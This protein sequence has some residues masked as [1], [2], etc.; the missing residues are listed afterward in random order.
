MKISAQSAQNCGLR[1]TFFMHYGLAHE[2]ADI[3]QMRANPM[4]PIA[5][6]KGHT[7]TVANRRTASCAT[8]FAGSMSIFH[9]RGEQIAF[10]AGGRA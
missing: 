8:S 7:V 6:N 5:E 3:Q 9:A 2:Q 10:I 1:K 4:F